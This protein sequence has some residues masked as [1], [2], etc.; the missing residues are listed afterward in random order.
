MYIQL[1]LLGSIL[2]APTA[3]T[4]PATFITSTSAT[5]NGTVNPNGTSQ[6][7]LSSM[8]LRPVMAAR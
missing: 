2:S 4:N 6:P 3:T 1:Q 7:S 5:L 8:G